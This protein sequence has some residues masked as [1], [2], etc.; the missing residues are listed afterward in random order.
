M[1]EPNQHSEGACPPLGPISAVVV[2]YQGEAY[3]EACIRSIQAQS[4]PVAEVIVVENDSTDGSLNLLNT[5]FR[6]VEILRMV[7]NVGACTAR[8]VGM[9]A[10]KYRWVLLVDNDVVLAEDTLE[11]LAGT[12]SAHEGAVMAQP[13]SLF[14]ADPTR[15][16]YDGGDFHYAGLIS[17]HNF[18]A[19]VSV[20]ASP[21]VEEIDVAISLCLLVDKKAVIDVGGFDESFFI[22]FE[23]L[24]LSHRLRLAGH[25]ILKVNSA[26]VLH[27]A[28]TAGIS[29]RE[30]TDYPGRRVFF[31]SRNRWLYMAKCHRLWT[32]LV[33]APGLLVYEAAW[34][35]F[36]AKQGHLSS[37]WRGKVA[38]FRRLPEVLR[39][40]RQV[41]RH[42]KIGDRGL[43]VGGPLTLSPNLSSSGGL[44]LRLL[45][46]ALRAWW[47]LCRWLVV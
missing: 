24:D 10:A 47:G 32:L 15:V 44:G 19:E 18:G 26:A 11:Q 27:D 17:L 9:R 23:D 34:V 43:L 31:H 35:V 21:A 41:Q 13:R 33:S 36:A 46:S 8:N 22:L 4:L 39:R 6:N 25:R 42:R 37:W 29:F 28:G 14:K 7:E 16:H 12:V 1:A 38:F 5:H 2:N 3:L 30:G 20:L 45:D 40:R